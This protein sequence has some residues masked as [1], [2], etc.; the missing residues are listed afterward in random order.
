MTHHPPPTINHYLTDT[1]PGLALDDNDDIYELG[2]ANSLF[3]VRLITHIEKAYEITI[4]NDE[5]RP[6]NF[7]TIT[8]INELIQ[9]LTQTTSP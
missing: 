4:P 5:L 1:Y 3:T 6:D 8:A 9:R 7:R 2:V